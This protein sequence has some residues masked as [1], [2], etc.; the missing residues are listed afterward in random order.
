MGVVEIFSICYE[1]L[2]PPNVGHKRE[3]RRK[4]PRRKV[5]LIQASS[6][7]C[8]AMGFNLGSRSKVFLTFFPLLFLLGARFDELSS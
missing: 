3:S 6:G 1:F 2:V 8:E 4:L 5:G 7:T